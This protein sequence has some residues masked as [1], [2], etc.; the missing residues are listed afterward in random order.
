MYLLVSLMLAL[1]SCGREGGNTH[2][3]N[4]G[5]GQVKQASGVNV[6]PAVLRAIYITP[7]NTLG[8]NSGAQFQLSARGYY[9]DTSVKDLTMMV[10]WTSS[11]TSILTISN[12]PDSKG[13]AIAVSKGYCSISAALNGIS[14]STIVGIN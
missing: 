11:D 1:T 12:S 10:V 9:S 3:N 13:R 8:I 4:I 7:S 2:L 14:A 6:R 5:A